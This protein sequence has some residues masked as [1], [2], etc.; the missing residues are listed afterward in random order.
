MFIAMNRFKVVPGSQIEF[1]Q[2]WTSR[3]SHL[4]EVAGFVVF[5]LL[6]ISRPG[7]GRRRSAPR[8]ATPAQTG[9]SISVIPNSRALR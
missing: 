3:D 7:P 5:H 2:V 9:R 8:I 4:Q 6:R 1:E